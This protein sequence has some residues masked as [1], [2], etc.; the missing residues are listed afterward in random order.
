MRPKF[1]IMFVVIS[2]LLPGARLAQ[3][4]DCNDKC[5]GNYDRCMNRVCDDPTP[6]VAN[7][8]N[9]I[10]TDLMNKCWYTCDKHNRPLRPVNPRE[11]QW[12]A[13][14]NDCN[15][16]WRTCTAD[17]DERSKPGG[18]FDPPPRGDLNRLE[19]RCDGTKKECLADCR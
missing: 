13:C 7:H 18:L 17:V 14:R 6:S 4:E 5:G 16:K 10:C 15:V 3:A 19:D 11:V 2:V 8:C 9:D 12:K 1:V